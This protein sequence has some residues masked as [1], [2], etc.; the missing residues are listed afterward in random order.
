MLTIIQACHIPLH[1]ALAIK[2]CQ[3]NN[4]YTFPVLIINHF[5]TLEKGQRHEVGTYTQVI[6]PSMLKKLPL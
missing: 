3:S 1:C 4:S 2:Y 5:H 6:L